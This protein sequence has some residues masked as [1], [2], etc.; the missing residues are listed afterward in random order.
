M[1]NMR[2]TLI[3]ADSL[4]IL[5]IGT[6]QYNG[7]LNKNPVALNLLVVVAFAACI[8]RHINYYKLT[9]RIY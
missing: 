4:F 2:S 9:R 8:I 3:L 6:M 5:T 1:V 7:G